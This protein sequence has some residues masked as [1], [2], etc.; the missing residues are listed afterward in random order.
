MSN[1]KL[2]EKKLR[3]EVKRLGGIA[4]KFV[5]LHVA[6]IPDRICLL[7]GGRVFFVEVKDEKAQVKPL[8]NLWRGRLEKLGFT[9]Y[10]LSSEKTLNIII[11]NERKQL[12][13]LSK[14]SRD[15]HPRE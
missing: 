2:L 11:Q 4:F 9:W 15:S 5:P 8:Q 1:E 12:T 13:R 3:E 14:T 6:G 7:P 10:L